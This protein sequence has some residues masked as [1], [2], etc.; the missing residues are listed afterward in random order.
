LMT[1]STCGSSRMTF[2]TTSTVIS[3][4]SH[5][6]ADIRRCGH[7]YKDDEDNPV[8]SLHIRVRTWHFSIVGRHRFQL[9]VR[10]RAGESHQ[11]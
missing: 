4:H 2:M 7:R 5:H 8:A 11:V 6:E 10:K 9:H 3:H 1:A